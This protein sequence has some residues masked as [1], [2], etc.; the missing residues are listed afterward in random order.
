MEIKAEA[1]DV[2]VSASQNLQ[3][4]FLL[5]LNKISMGITGSDLDAATQTAGVI[6]ISS[7][8]NVNLFNIILQNVSNIGDT[9]MEVEQGDSGDDHGGHGS[10]N[11]GH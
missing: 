7:S 3:T 9:K 4:I 2:V 6:V 1:K 8:S 5:N 11:G 10:D